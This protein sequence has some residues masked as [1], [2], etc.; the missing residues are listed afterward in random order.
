MNSQ[1]LRVNNYTSYFVLNM[2]QCFFS[3]MAILSLTLPPVAGGLTSGCEDV[4]VCLCGE[5]TFGACDF[6]D[7][8]GTCVQLVPGEYTCRVGETGTLGKAG[9]TFSTNMTGGVAGSS[10]FVSVVVK[11][12]VESSLK[13]L[14]EGTDGNSASTGG[15]GG[16]GLL[17]DEIGP[18]SSLIFGRTI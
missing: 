2:F 13:K 18:P 11:A 5:A 7:D 9:C 3:N 1:L 10:C 8:V 14:T 17:E 12:S 4:T 6:A 16:N 15:N